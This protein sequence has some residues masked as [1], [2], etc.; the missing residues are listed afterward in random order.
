MR[1]LKSVKRRACDVFVDVAA[2]LTRETVLF[3]N[4]RRGLCCLL[5]YL[6]SRYHILL[7]GVIVK[8]TKNS[9]YNSLDFVWVED[10]RRAGNTLQLAGVYDYKM[11][12]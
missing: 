7:V 1:L 3:N 8:Q 4:M 9:L 6:L 11:S 2:S 5:F 12:F 10:K